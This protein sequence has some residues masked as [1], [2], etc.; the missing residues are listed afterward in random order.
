MRYLTGEEN[1][2]ESLPHGPGA[3]TV[4]RSKFRMKPHKKRL[5]STCWVVGISLAVMTAYEAAKQAVMPSITIWQSH[6]VTILFGAL[7][8]G[9]AAHIIIRRYDAVNRKLRQEILEHERTD[10]EKTRFRETLEKMVWQRTTELTISNRKLEQEISGRSHILEALLSSEERFRSFVETISEWVW[11]TDENFRFTYSSPKVSDL[12]GY[13]PSEI[14]GKTPFHLMPDE[15]A[16]GIAVIFENFAQFLQPFAFVENVNTHKTGH[17]ITLETG[18][19]PLLDDAGKCRGY[20]GIS[21]DIT[22]RKLAEEALRESEAT[23]R[24]FFNANAILMSVIELEDSDF[25][26]VMPNKRIADFYGLSLEEMTGMRASG[27]GI[28][29]EF[30]RYWLEVLRYCLDVRE[31]V[32]FEYEFPYRGNTYWYQASISMVFDSNA[33]RPRF[34]FA[35]V[36]VTQRK[37]AEQEIQQLAYFDTLTGLP[38]RVLMNDRLHQILAQSAREGWQ[39]GILFLDLDRFKLIN[40]TLGHAAGDSLLKAVAQR[41]SSRLRSSDT[42]AR[43]GGDE[44]VVVLSAVKQEQDIA[45]TT[46][47]I[48]GGFS[49]PFDIEGQDIYISASIG[50]A[51]FPL[52]GQDVGSLLR[53]ADTAM[54]VAKESGRDNFQFFSQEMNN[55][56]VERMSLERNLRKALERQEFTLFYQPQFDVQH[57]RI[58]GMEALLRWNHPEMGCISP[59][60][61]IPIAEETGLIVPIGEWVLRTACLQAKGWTDDGFSEICMAVNISGCQF[62]QNNLPQLV[63]EVLSE[64]GLNPAN[65]ELELTESILMENDSSAIDM[66]RELKTIG[67]RLAIDDFGTG[68]S[69]L[70]CLKHFPIDRL[71]IDQL[72]IKDITTNDDDA[73]IADAIIALAR[74]LR[75]DVIAEG[76]ETREQVAFLKSRDCFEMQGFYFSRPVPADEA[77]TLLEIGHYDRETCIPLARG[78]C[79]A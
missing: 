46:E 33:P 3:H 22:D 7:V 5:I 27:L 44:F 20:R 25:V 72:F 48:L 8:A 62:K 70:T 77:C 53:N 57:G 29:K 61:F 49:A 47:E 65:L 58:I 41:L 35:A 60:K 69:S 43:L 30:I 38:N 39:V 79:L 67:V 19:A 55:R 18:G 54:Y 45:H 56:A 74:S 59:G 42:V 76:V 14:I 32:T 16:R 28:P 21:R 15:E 4:L 71:K 51:I 34:S 64:T 36:E 10:R 31:T 9:I 24:G 2:A 75:M 13:H 1:A 11:E 73:S 66:L 40:D 50:V 23:L 12:L 78:G 17:Q 52:D 26:Y 6:F 63:R 68:Y 37:Q